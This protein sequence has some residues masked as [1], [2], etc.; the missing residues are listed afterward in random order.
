M[1]VELKNMW[2]LPSAHCPLDFSSPFHTNDS[3]FSVDWMFIK[4]YHEV[5]QSK[6]DIELLRTETSTFLGEK[7]QMK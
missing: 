2:K 6:A 3:Y 7:I 1:L 4:I 5:N